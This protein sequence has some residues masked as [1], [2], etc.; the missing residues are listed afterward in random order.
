MLLL[1]QT[2][3]GYL[4]RESLKH[5]IYGSSITDLFHHIKFYLSAAKRRMFWALRF[6]TSPPTEMK[7]EKKSEEEKKFQ[8][9]KITFFSFFFLPNQLYMKP[10]YKMK[11]AVGP[12]KEKV[13]HDVSDLPVIIHDFILQSESGLLPL[14]L[15][16]N[17]NF[18]TIFK[19]IQCCRNH[20]AGK[21]TD[22]N[23][24]GLFF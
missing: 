9:K 1:K 24:S 11:S 6:F 4:K 8:A 13:A 17:T 15:H 2:R 7:I 10:K 20:W 21:N 12:L 3:H 5:Y 18:K 19:M 22:I 23:L 16:Y 14:W